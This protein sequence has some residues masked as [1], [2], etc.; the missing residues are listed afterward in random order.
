[1]ENPKLLETQ[2]RKPRNYTEYALVATVV[3]FVM[4]IVT[5][6]MGFSA[7]LG[8]YLPDEVVLYV[9]IS[10]NAF[11]SIVAIVFSIIG[12]RK[13][14]EMTGPFALILL[15]LFLLL[16]VVGTLADYR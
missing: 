4:Y 2:P 9:S 10:L 15:N 6:V 13:S 14:G 1:M 8:S 3:A 16:P 7:A 12:W 11:C 5:G